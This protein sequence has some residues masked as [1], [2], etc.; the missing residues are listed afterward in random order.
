MQITNYK[1]KN[2]KLN[3]TKTL[4]SYLLRHHQKGQKSFHKVAENTYK[5]YTDKKPNMQECLCGS[6][7]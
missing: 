6:L 5:T 2:D 7:S 1:G 4:K 3:Y